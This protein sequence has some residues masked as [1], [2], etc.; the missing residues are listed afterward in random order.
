MSSLEEMNDE[1]R[2]AMRTVLATW[3]ED[4][5][6]EG[7]HPAD[8]LSAVIGG[9]VHIL[10]EMSHSVKAG[11]EDRLAGQQLRGWSVEAPD[12][13]AEEMAGTRLYLNKHLADVMNGDA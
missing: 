9:M 2:T 13:L 1:V 12:D 10:A 5:I 11:R 8:A 3:L 6:K 4:R 7:S